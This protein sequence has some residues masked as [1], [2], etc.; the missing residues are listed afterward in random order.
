VLI[1]FAALAL[2]LITVGG[3][4]WPA[5]RFKAVA[6][7]AIGM[8]AYSELM[9][10]VSL[11]GLEIGL[12]PLL[13]WLIVPVLGLGLTRRRLGARRLILQSGNGV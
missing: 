1:A 7:L 11:G 13:Q 6:T 10:V 3:S 12:S 5:V 4:G 9:P 2:A 8:W